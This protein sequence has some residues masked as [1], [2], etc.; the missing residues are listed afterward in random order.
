MTTIIFQHCFSC[1]EAKYSSECIANTLKKT[2]QNYTK[3]KK[4]RCD[5]VHYYLHKNIN[6]MIKGSV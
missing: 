4:Q 5:T 3:W 6:Y 1:K 2:I